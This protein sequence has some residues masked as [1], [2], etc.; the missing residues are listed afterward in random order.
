[1]N[2]TELIE[3]LKTAISKQ[4][5]NKNIYMVGVSWL[6][7]SGKSQIAQK[8]MESLKKDNISVLSFSGDSFQFPREYK[9]NFLEKSWAEQ[10]IKRTI[11]FI[12][13]E[14]NLLK[15]LIFQ[16]PTISF[17]FL[18][19][20]TNE[21]TKKT[22][23]LKYPLTVIVESIYLF[24]QSL[25]S[26]FDYKIFLKISKDESLRRAKLR[27]RDIE[28]YWWEQGVETKYVNKNFAGYELFEKRENPK[29]YADIIIDNNDWKSP[30]IINNI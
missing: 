28:L 19:Y 6:D 22:I 10:H 4:S 29:Q 5:K 23:S 9:E 27:K 7:A 1:M 12:S 3:S 26:Y 14:T 20:D 8:I 13:L 17:D 30:V 15:P 18:N 24:Q 16:K 2:H 21:K 11:D 25:V